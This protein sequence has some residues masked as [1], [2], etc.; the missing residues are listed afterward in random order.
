MNRGALEFIR[1]HSSLRSFSITNLIAG[2]V[3]FFFTML[4]MD[5][6]SKILVFFMGI[7]TGLCIGYFIL[8]SIIS[9][10]A[11]SKKRGGK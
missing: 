4:V 10:Y 8:T 3:G 6:R 1:H 9:K 2:I 5:S 11:F 7:S